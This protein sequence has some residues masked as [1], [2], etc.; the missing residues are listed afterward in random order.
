MLLRENRGM[1]SRKVA[2]HGAL[3]QCGMTLRAT[4]VRFP[5]ITENAVQCSRAAVTVTRGA[6]FTQDHQRLQVMANADVKLWVA[7]EQKV[8]PS[9]YQHW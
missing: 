7:G 5:R 2:S 4:G 3:Q 9:R 1:E 6:Q 8:A